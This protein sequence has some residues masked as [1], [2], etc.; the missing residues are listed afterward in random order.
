MLPRLKEIWQVCFDEEEKY[1]DFVFGG[2]LNPTQMLIET[3]ENNLPVAML[4]WKLLRFTTPAQTFIGAYI[5]GICTL[6][7]HRGKGISTALMEKAHEMFQREGIQLSCLVPAQRSLFGFYADRGFE[8]R[9]YYKSI[10]LS[11][12]EIP[13]SPRGGVL[14]TGALE[15]FYD[16]RVGAFSSCSLFGD[17]DVDYL[18]LT[19][20]ECRLLGGDVLRF[21]CGGNQGYAVCYPLEDGTLLVKE[22]VVDQKD[23]G[24]LLSALDK[25]Y[26]MKRYHLRLPADFVF[27]NKWAVEILP[28][29]MVKWY[30]KEAS[31]TH[32]GDA[33]WFAFGLD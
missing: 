15:N 7:E 30:D 5:Y 20:S 18:K 24:V 13:K 4:N 27:D 16:K 26:K 23:I 33:S 11:R 9:F 3:D 21:S 14:S 29:A 28:F 22:A 1:V 31:R 8:T 10:N 19:T 25:R 6:P 2:L 32:L 17:W 12:K